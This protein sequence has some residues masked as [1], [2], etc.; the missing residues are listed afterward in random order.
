MWQ[1]L[2]RVHVLC[3]GYLLG[4]AVCGFHDACESYTRV[5]T[6]HNEVIRL[7]TDWSKWAWSI[8]VANFAKS[9]LDPRIMLNLHFSPCT[10]WSLS[11][12]FILSLSHKQAAVWKNCL[13]HF[14]SGQNTEECRAGN[15][16]L[17]H[18]VNLKAYC[19]NGCVGSA[20]GSVACIS[21]LTASLNKPGSLV[22]AVY[23]LLPYNCMYVCIIGNVCVLYHSLLFTFVSLALHNAWN[24][25]HIR[26]SE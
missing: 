6:S 3:C 4:G 9:S 12:K 24:K 20:N 13:S 22:I 7:G 23:T 10:E 19:V 18:Q 15:T 26:M 11:Y 17:S 25:P 1:F 16:V 2:C 8:F 21:A 5:R 14:Y